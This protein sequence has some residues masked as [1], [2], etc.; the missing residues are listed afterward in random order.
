M[1]N[2]NNN[3]SMSKLCDALDLSTLYLESLM[4]GEMEM[5][6]QAHIVHEGKL[7]TVMYEGDESL[8]N[9]YDQPPTLVRAR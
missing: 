5:T 8:P 4:F 6:P 1:G 9:Y 3:N 7:V 2:N